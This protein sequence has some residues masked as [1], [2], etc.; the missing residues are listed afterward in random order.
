MYTHIFACVY[1]LRYRLVNVATYSNILREVNICISIYSSLYTV[2]IFIHIYI[3]A[4]V[5]HMSG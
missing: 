5:F 3:C 2:C 1:M 4:R